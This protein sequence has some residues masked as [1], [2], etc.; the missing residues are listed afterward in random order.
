[1]VNLHQM[2]TYVA[3]R[4]LCKPT[5][6]DFAPVTRTDIIVSFHKCC[7]RNKLKSFNVF[8]FIRFHG[9]SRFSHWKV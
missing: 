8:S 6:N 9:L 1:M 5:S 4:T 2:E 7:L 3:I